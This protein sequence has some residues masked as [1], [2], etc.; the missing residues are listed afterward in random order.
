MPFSAVFLVLIAVTDHAPIRPFLHLFSIYPD[1][2]SPW[3][4]FFQSMAGRLFC[5]C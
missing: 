5:P 1:R 4:R 2:L 3:Y